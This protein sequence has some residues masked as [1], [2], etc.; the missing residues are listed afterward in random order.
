[1]AQNQTSDWY[2]LP[3]GNQ[4]HDE[5]QRRIW[6][7]LYYLRNGQQNNASPIHPLMAGGLSGTAF[8]AGGFTMNS[9]PSSK[10]YYRMVIQ[11]G[12]IVAVS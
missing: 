7:N 9:G 6:E 12:R 11:E 3:T 1:M 4:Q 10:T 5:N 8:F 2:P